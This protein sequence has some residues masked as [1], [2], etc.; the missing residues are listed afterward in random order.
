MQ[1]GKR[2]NVSGLAG[3]LL[4]PLL[5]LMT[6]PP[7][8][9]TLAGYYWESFYVEFAVLGACAAFTVL[10]YFLIVNFQGR[11]LARREIEILEVVEGAE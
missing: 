5:L 9:A 7:M 2:M 8:A 11:A 1:F 4:I 6:I 3:L 10:F